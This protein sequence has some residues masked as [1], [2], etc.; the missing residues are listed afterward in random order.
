MRASSPQAYRSN[1]IDT[2]DTVIS[3][4]GDG[5]TGRQPRR[6]SRCLSVPWS[7]SLRAYDDFGVVT[8]SLREAFGLTR[9]ADPCDVLRQ[10]F[11]L[12][13]CRREL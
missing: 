1:E 13:L 8:R 7:A 6:A 10:L 11:L 9:H 2:T 5:R 4:R 3:A 12:W